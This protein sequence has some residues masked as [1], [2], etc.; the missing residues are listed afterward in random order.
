MLAYMRNNDS[1]DNINNIIVY[2][3]RIYRLGEYPQSTV[4]Y[5]II[6]I[7]H[8]NICGGVLFVSHE[9]MLTQL[10]QKPILL[11]FLFITLVDGSVQG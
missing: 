11:I 2:I 3:R 6:G 4:I 9:V 10:D 7:K 5:V 1:N 8:M